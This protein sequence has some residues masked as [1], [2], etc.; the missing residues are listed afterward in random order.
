MIYFTFTDFPPEIEDEIIA[1]ED[2]GE[3]EETPGI[4]IVSKQFVDGISLSLSY[5]EK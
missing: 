5:L 3:V 2:A 1:V 4:L